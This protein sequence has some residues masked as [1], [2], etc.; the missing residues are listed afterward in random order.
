MPLEIVRRLQAMSFLCLF[1]EVFFYSYN[2]HFTMMKVALLSLT[3]PSVQ[4]HFFYSRLLF[5][6]LAGNINSPRHRDFVV[7]ELRSSEDSAALCAME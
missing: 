1:C 7:C 4:P 5:S 6:A 3:P 2:Y